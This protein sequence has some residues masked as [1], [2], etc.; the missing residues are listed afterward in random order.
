MSISMSMARMLC[1]AGVQDVEAPLFGL[2]DRGGQ[3]CAA[4]RWLQGRSR[5]AGADLRRVLTLN[6]QLRDL[7]QAHGL[8]PVY[9]FE[10]ASPSGSAVPRRPGIAAAD[11]NARLAQNGG[12]ASVRN[13]AVRIATHCFNTADEVEYVVAIMAGAD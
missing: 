7:A 10:P 2:T 3:P 11:P 1:S 13:G 6:G 5:G 12:H 4:L 8:E 9:R